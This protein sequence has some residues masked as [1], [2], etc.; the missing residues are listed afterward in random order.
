MT[1]LSEVIRFRASVHKLTD[2]EFHQFILTLVQKCGRDILITSL[3]TM[4][5]SGCDRSSQSLET[6]LNIITQIIESR[7]TKP[8]PANA[9][10]ITMQSLPSV[11]VGNL[12][13]YLK[14]PEYRSFQTAN[15]SI[16][17][18]C[19]T[20]NTIHQT[21]YDYQSEGFQCAPITNLLAT[22]PFLEFVGM[23]CGSYDSFSN[24][25]N[26]IERG[27]C[28]R[29]YKNKKIRLD[30]FLNVVVDMTKYKN[31]LFMI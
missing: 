24:I 22:R 29:K 9:Y 11:L 13:S 10:N 15:R 17:I 4:F 8:K 25:C 19:N 21:L 26:A 7:K 23:G 1:S 6:T 30:L 12:A 5:T 20:P 28:N 2:T 3:F 18:G 31:I 14:F 27:L 16:Y